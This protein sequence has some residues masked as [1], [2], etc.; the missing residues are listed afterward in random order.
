MCKADESLDG[1]VPHFLPLG[2]VEKEIYQRRLVRGMPVF[3]E[4]Q[5]FS[6]KL[7]QLADEF[8][9]RHAEAA[10]AEK[11]RRRYQSIAVAAQQL[12][13][14]LQSLSEHEMGAL[15]E[16]QTTAF[17]DYVKR[18]PDYERDYNLGYAYKAAGEKYAARKASS[19][20]TWQDLRWVY[21]GSKKLAQGRKRGRQTNRAEQWA[22]REFVML[23]LQA[24]WSPLQIANSGTEKRSSQN[25]IPSDTVRCLAAV[26]AHQGVPPQLA[27][28]KAQSA[29]RALRNGFAHQQWEQIWGEEFHSVSYTVS[30]QQMRPVGEFEIGEIPHFGPTLAKSIKVVDIKS[31]LPRLV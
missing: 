19:M 10:D 5:V 17:S 16:S 13:F 14:A 4:L 8:V 21:D 20:L 23:C 2:L 3:F 12:Q 29:L 25:P 24:G 11:R 30:L 7:A 27:L 18:L 1:A 31:A 22:A 9:S 15:A 28:V 26:I 6:E